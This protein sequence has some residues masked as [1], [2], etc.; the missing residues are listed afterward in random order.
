MLHTIIFVF[1]PTPPPPPPQK[2]QDVWPKLFNMH[3]GDILYYKDSVLDHQYE[4]QVVKL[5]ASLKAIKI[6]TEKETNYSQHL[7]NPINFNLYF[8]WTEPSRKCVTSRKPKHVAE[9]FDVEKALKEA[10]KSN[11]KLLV[12]ARQSSR[13]SKAKSPLDKGYHLDWNK[14]VQGK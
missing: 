11:E 13:F 7:N 2:I 5:F 8:Y 12:N 6:E 1:S 9:V 10:Q 3:N 14:N 4:Y